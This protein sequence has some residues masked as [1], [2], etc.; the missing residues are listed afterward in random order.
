MKR[1]QTRPCKYP[2]YKNHKAHIKAVL[3]ENGVP[4]IEYYVDGETTIEAVRSNSAI[5]ESGMA[6][7]F[8]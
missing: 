2:R 6:S 8:H 4:D 7:D 3:R 1:R 5:R